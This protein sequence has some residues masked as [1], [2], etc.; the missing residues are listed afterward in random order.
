M[1]AALLAV[2]CGDEAI[3][4]VSDDDPAQPAYL[5]TPRGQR[6]LPPGVV[7]IAWEGQGDTHFI[8]GCRYDIPTDSI[9]GYGTQQLRRCHLR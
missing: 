5:Q 6:Q 1:A 7:A 4:T 8:E 3:P 9:R 2:G